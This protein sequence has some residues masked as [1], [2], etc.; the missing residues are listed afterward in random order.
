MAVVYVN[1][2]SQVLEWRHD[3]GDERRH[4][5][6]FGTL[7]TR[8]IRFDGVAN[9]L[10]FEDLRRHS[11]R[12]TVIQNELRKDGNPVTLAGASPAFSDEEL[13]RQLNQDIADLASPLMMPQLQAIT[14]RGLR[15]LR[16][17]LRK[18]R[19]LD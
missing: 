2:D 10:I 11:T 7:A 5:L 8:I 14:R 18:I 13:V 16:H 1:P 17:V 6:P 4:P 15:I 19:E 9:R 12:Y 3:Q